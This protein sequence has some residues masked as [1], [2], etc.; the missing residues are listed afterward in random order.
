MIFWEGVGVFENR[1]QKEGLFRRR[2][3]CSFVIA[4]DDSYADKAAVR[5]DMEGI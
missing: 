2:Y 4:L 3:Y 5:H 1:L